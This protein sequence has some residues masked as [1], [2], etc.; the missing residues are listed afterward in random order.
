MTNPESLDTDDDGDFD[1]HEFNAW[2]KERYRAHV[3]RNMEKYEKYIFQMIRLGFQEVPVGAGHRFTHSTGLRIDFWK[4]SGKWTEV[5]TNKYTL[6]PK[7]MIQYVKAK[8]KGAVPAGVPYLGASNV[9]NPVSG[10]I[11]FRVH[12]S[13]TT[14]DTWP[15]AG[16]WDTDP[17]TPPWET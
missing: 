1:W 12:G 6:G 5:G 7:R 10:A 9:K 16:E 8:L 14:P 4:Q 2:K 11:G 17:N 13:T 15:P 3:E